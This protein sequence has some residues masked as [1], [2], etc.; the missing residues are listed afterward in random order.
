MKIVNLGYFHVP[1][2]YLAAIVQTAARKNQWPLDKV[3]FSTQVTKWHTVDDINESTQSICLIEG[4]YLEGASWDSTNHCL[5]EQSNKQLIQSMPLIK[6]I[7]VESYQAN[8]NNSLPTPVYVTSDR[9]NAMGIG[10]VFE[11]NLPT[12]K[13]LSHWI[14][15]GVCLLLNTD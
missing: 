8:V 2:A 5:I 9:R 12:N 11:A 7:P 13:H 3:T 14:L 10:F 6:I 1:E 4:L 15:N